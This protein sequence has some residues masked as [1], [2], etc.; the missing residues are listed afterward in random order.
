MDQWMGDLFF[1]GA[2]PSEI[3]AMGFRRMKYWHTW[4]KAMAEQERQE[5]G[6]RQQE[7]GIA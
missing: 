1:R 4:A 5:M 3:E 6:R 7:A 2:S